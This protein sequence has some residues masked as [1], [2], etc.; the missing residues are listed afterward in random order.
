[1]RHAWHTESPAAAEAVAGL[2][3]PIAHKSLL[4]SRWRVPAVIATE[5][6]L[7]EGRFEVLVAPEDGG[8]PPR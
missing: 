8:K 3:L 6:L 5:E 2:A 7:A 4:T 1:M